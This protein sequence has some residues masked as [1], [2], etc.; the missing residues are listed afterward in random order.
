[1]EQGGREKGKEKGKEKVEERTSAKKP[2]SKT[3]E[4][5]GPSQWSKEE[6]SGGLYIAATAARSPALGV[7]KRRSI[8]LTQKFTST[9]A[10][11]V[12]EGNYSGIPS[13]EGYSLSKKVRWADE[14]HDRT[15]SDSG[16][17]KTTP[18]VA[19]GIKRTYKEALLTPKPKSTQPPRRPPNL[20]TFPVPP[21][22]SSLRGRCFRCLG[23]NHWAYNCRGPIRCRRCYKTGHI[24]RSCMDRLPMSVYRAMRARP[25]Y[26]SAFV[27][28]TEDFYTRQNR[29]RNAILVDVLPPK[30]L[31]HFPHE[32]IANKLASR[33]GGFPADFHV[34]RYSERDFVV[35]LPEWVP[36][37][38][39]LRREIL[40]LEELKLQCF[41][42]NPW[43][44]ARVTQLTYNVWIQLMISRSEWWISRGTRCLISVNYLSNIPENLEITV[45]DVSTSVLI[46]LERWGRREF[47]APENP[48]NERTDQHDPQQR[49]P[50][51]HRRSG[52]SV[53]GRRS[54][55]AGSSSSD[56]LWN[57]SEIRDRRRAIDPPSGLTWLKTPLS[58]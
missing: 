8:K 24:A 6:A 42:W 30:I 22:Y 51:M 16:G 23:S 55:A 20:H 18:S 36:S 53:R 33:F 25:S 12:N 47:A 56:A 28:L 43:S 7:L 50:D 3:G 35:F 13:I 46:Q 14:L 44:H 17:G 29:C 32:H 2:G 31:G 21:G 19:T 58:S 41:P 40:S 54:S 27:P 48:P 15:R 39:L 52:G 38:Q 11:R 37:E 1:M 9:K 45:G 10:S 34:A 5:P 49:G 26:L 4:R 57:S